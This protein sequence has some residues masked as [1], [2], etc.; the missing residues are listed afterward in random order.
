MGEESEEDHSKAKACQASNPYVGIS[1]NCLGEVVDSPSR[2]RGERARVS[3]VCTSAR[4]RGST[5]RPRRDA[6]VVQ[7]GHATSRRGAVD[8]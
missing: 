1:V 4:L 3:G 8:S 2:G 6:L 7:G 5:L